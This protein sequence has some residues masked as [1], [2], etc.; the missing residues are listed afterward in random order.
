MAGIGEF[1]GQF[2]KGM[3]SA[4]DG[5]H[6]RVWN[7]LKPWVANLVPAATRKWLPQFASG[8]ICE[9]PV[10]RRGKVV[11]ECERFG[12]AACDVCHRPT[13]LNHGRIDQHGDI[14]CY[15]CV[16][17]AQQVV[18]AHQ[19]A[20]REAAPRDQQERQARQKPPAG[21]PPPTPGEILAAKQMLGLMPDA[22]WDQVKKARKN[23]LAQNHPDKH[24]SERAKAVA[25][26]RFKEIQVAYELLKRVYPDA[27]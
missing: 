12:V 7:E 27:A 10:M 26:A 3:T 24:K 22:T 9:V 5:V 1:F 11:G 8:V 6:M 13:C 15:I 14:I 20:R 16:G 2:L 4:E 18:P 21:K 19:R 17:D 23:L 25:G